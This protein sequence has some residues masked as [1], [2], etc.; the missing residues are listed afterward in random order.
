M[1]HIAYRSV[2]LNLSKQFNQNTC[3]IQ[4]IESFYFK[5]VLYKQRGGEK[6][7]KETRACTLVFYRIF[8]LPWFINPIKTI[9]KLRLN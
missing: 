2:F 9:N 5:Y 4:S 7:Y 8:Y 1:I 3:Y 6:S